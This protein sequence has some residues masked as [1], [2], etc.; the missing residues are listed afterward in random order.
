[1]VIKNNIIYKLII[2]GCDFYYYGSTDNKIVRLE[3]HKTDC[4][5]KKKKSYHTKKYKTIREL[6]ITKQNFNHKVKMIVIEDNITSE[7]LLYREDHY[8]NLE[9]TWCLNSIRAVAKP[10]TKEQNTLSTKNWRNK[11]KNKYI[12]EYCDYNTSDKTDM[13][14]HIVSKK[15]KN[16]FL[17]FCLKNEQDIHIGNYNDMGTQTNTEDIMDDS[18][19]NELQL[20]IDRLMEIITLQD[21]IK[22]LKKSIDI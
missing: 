21:K 5:N 18:I 16:K 22:E 13:K 2:I 4:F 14:R 9:D 10:R 6:G 3:K 1:M 17:L 12:C 19:T 20:E 11:N 8:I 15:H 7:D